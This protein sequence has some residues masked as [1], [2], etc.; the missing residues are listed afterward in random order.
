MTD[1]ELQQKRFMAAAIDAAAGI[2]IAVVFWMIDGAMAAS[3]G[4]VV[5]ASVGAGLLPRFVAFVGALLGLGYVLLRDVVAGGNSLG[6]KMLGLRVVKRAGA[7]P[8]VVDSAKRNAPFA[9]G[10][11]L[12]ALSAILGVI[13]CLGT[14][15]SCLL[16]P[17]I[18]LGSV[19]TL[20]I[21]V[22]EVM[23]IVQDPEGVRFGDQLA[24]TR[25]V[26]G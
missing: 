2:G 11:G 3:S 25:V 19:A 6:K 20:A 17:L 9:V 12:N 10:P 15:V 5:G 24:Q 18:I 23:R 8:G 26:E 4:T 22:V 16:W 21:V 7:A 13:P 14:A 1:S